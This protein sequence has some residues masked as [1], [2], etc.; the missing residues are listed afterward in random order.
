VSHTGQVNSH[1]GPWRRTAFPPG[2]WRR[3]AATRFPASLAG[4]LRD[5]PFREKRGGVAVQRP[6]MQRAA[7]S[8][9]I[10]NRDS[11]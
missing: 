3:D 5:Q 6:E 8:G 7:P 1:R 10:H 9:I 11:P 4:M 2:S